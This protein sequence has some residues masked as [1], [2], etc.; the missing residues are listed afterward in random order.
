MSSISQFLQDIQKRHN[1]YAHGPLSATCEFGRFDPYLNCFDKENNY[2]ITL[3]PAMDK[4]EFEKL[5]RD[6]DA[7]G[8]KRDG[9]FFR[10]R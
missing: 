4:K 2:I 8:F 9:N 7:L 10:I 1:L 3:N 6:L 5:K